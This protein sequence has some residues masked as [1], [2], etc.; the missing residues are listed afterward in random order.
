M[1]TKLERALAKRDRSHLYGF[2]D[3]KIVVR[4]PAIADSGRVCVL[5]GDPHRNATLLQA[6]A[7]CRALDKLAKQ[8]GVL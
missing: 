7:I 1:T 4:E 3:G 5:D 8:E 2:E 6:D